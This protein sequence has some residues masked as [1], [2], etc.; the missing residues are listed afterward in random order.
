MA[1]LMRIIQQFDPASEEEF[2]ALEKKF[3]ELE[4]RKKDFPSGKRM[5][6]VSSGIPVNSLVWQCEFP[7][8]ETAYKTL[9]FFNDDKEHDVLFREQVR[10]MKEVRIEFYKT[11]D[12]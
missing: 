10:Y 6:P 7:D 8:M 2:M 4:K 9:S 1:I 12:F 5:Q 3:D 11:L